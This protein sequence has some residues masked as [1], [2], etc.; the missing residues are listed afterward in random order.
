MKRTLVLDLDGTLVD[1]LDDLATAMNN[2]LRARSLKLTD[3]AELKH[4]VGDGASLLLVRVFAAR[5]VPADNSALD[6][7]VA[8]YTAHPAEATQPF[9][10]VAE[11]L[12]SLA[13]QG[14]QFAICTNKPETAARALL[15]KLG[16]EG[17]FVA[18]GGGDSFP[19][20]KPDPAHLLSTLAA[21]G[22]RADSAIMVGDHAND[23][24]AAS[25]AGLPCIFAAWGY[26]LPEMSQ[27]AAAKAA[28]F[29]EL[30]G[31]CEQLVPRH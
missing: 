10:G 21:A 1:S 12:G 11:T 6:E 14:W 17:L 31:L 29:T 3:R 28:R 4:M 2:V 20:R 18:V 8:D 25:G 22:G 23:V 19:T 5:H 9:P 24:S 26:G 15:R 13:E 7:F 16:M 30:A 27:G